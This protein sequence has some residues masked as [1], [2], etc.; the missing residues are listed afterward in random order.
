MTTQPESNGGNPIQSLTAARD[1]AS[2]KVDSWNNWYVAAVAA[3]A[4][5]AVVVFWTSRKVIV[6]SRTLSRSQDEL[7]IEKERQAAVA[8]SEADRK[9]QEARE[10]ADEANRQAEEAK[11]EATRLALNAE[12]LKAQNLATEQKLESERAQRLEL[13]KSL[14][15]RQIGI[16]PDPKS[17]GKKNIERLLP[18]GRT[19]VI[20]QYLPDTETAR[21]ALAIKSVLEQASWNIVSFLPQPQMNQEFFDGVIVF[22][23]LATGPEPPEENVRN[24]KA[25]KALVGFLM[26]QNVVARTHPSSDRLKDDSISIPPDTIRVSVGF[27]PLQYFDHPMVKRAREQTEE[28]LRR[29]DERFGEK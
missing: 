8:I 20:L 11:A 29:L 16:G 2:T 24:A 12:Q 18:F 23:P 27:K 1:K 13:E 4:I 7:M 22:A 21:T 26:D 25:A 14:A 28:I 6:A 17:P 5:I 10:R 19:R 3:T 15:P 9:A